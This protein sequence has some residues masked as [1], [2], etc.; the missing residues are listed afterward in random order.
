MKIEFSII[1]DYRQEFCDDKCLFKNREN[2]KRV[3]KKF[4][5]KNWCFIYLNWVKSTMIFYFSL[6][7]QNSDDKKVVN[8]SNFWNF[9]AFYEKHN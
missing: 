9:D 4:T 2:S 7:F 1:S 5:Q 6:W 3:T 8:A